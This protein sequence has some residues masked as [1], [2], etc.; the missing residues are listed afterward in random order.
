MLCALFLLLRKHQL[1]PLP[2]QNPETKR[3][4]VHPDLVSQPPAACVP[5]VPQ[6]GALAQRRARGRCAESTASHSVS[7]C[8]SL[9]CYSLL[10]TRKSN[11][12]P[13]QLVLLHYANNVL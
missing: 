13:S 11:D 1:W 2:R 6:R 4:L 10:D 7:L 12:F 9:I 5:N 3:P 8:S